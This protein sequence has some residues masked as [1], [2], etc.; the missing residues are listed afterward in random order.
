MSR[1]TLVLE[2]GRDGG[3]RAYGL[4]AD[5]C[6]FHLFDGIDYRL[7]AP[8]ESIDAARAGFA[9]FVLVEGIVDA[10]QHGLERDS[11]VAPGFNERPVEGGEQENR[12]AA[13]LEVIF[14]F[15]EIVEVVFQSASSL[16]GGVIRMRPRPGA[17]IPLVDDPQTVEGQRVVYLR[18]VLRIIRDQV[19]ESACRHAHGLRA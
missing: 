1:D 5:R 11:G 13:T 19:R 10:A 15:R 6:F 2:A 17:A 9:G 8:G 3:C 4:C 7:R 16:C 12:A 18:D 14:D